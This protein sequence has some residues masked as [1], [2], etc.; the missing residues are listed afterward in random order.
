M[1]TEKY[2]FLKAFEPQEI[3]G[4]S[5][6]M[7]RYG[8]PDY[9]NAVDNDE[10]RFRGLLYIAEN[11]GF[12]FRKLEHPLI[13]HIASG[14]SSC[15]HG[16]LNI[17]VEKRFIN[18]IDQAQELLVNVD[19]DESANEDTRSNPTTNK[20]VTITDTVE[21]F[22]ASK[23]F[24]NL[25]KSRNRNGLQRPVIIMGIFIPGLVGIEAI[26]AMAKHFTVV[27]ALIQTEQVRNSIDRVGS[28]YHQDMQVIKKAVEVN[29]E[30]VWH[31]DEDVFDD[32]RYRHVSSIYIT[33]KN[34]VTP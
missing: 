17:L 34:S 22:F 32:D 19:N 26:E 31:A 18:N 6:A 5:P 29:K 13:V 23:E 24:Q 9:P 10:R 27:G 3:S 25:I 8:S 4:N 30:L 33:R 7:E 15:T 14:Y 21:N 16:L 20:I 2:P 1:D 28:L 11:A 12:N